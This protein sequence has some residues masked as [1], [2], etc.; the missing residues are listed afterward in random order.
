MPVSD[1]AG[2]EGERG[3]TSR[4]RQL[5]FVALL[6]RITPELLAEVA[7]RQQDEVAYRRL[8]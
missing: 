1:C 2:L 5:R 7:L 8:N 6:H 4:N 3:A